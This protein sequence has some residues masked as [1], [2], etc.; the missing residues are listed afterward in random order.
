LFG[1][2]G[3]GGTYGSTIG[4]GSGGGGSSFG[5]GT[6]VYSLAG[7]GGANA[8]AG[9]NGRILLSAFTPPV[10]VSTLTLTPGFVVGDL[11]P[12]APVNLGGT[13][14]EPSSPWSAVLRS[15][16]TV[17]A[18]GITDSSGNFSLGANLPSTV[19]VGEHTITL[20]GTNI[21]GESWTRVVYI[22]VGSSMR[23]TYLSTIGAEGLPALAGP[24]TGRQLAATGSQAEALLPGALALLATG[25]GI[26]LFSARRR[27][28]VR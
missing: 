22:T 26:L 4:G 11:A 2:G 17:F 23:I 7:N 21:T 3:G 16:P 18:S 6:P 19:S 10:I 1:G 24:T 8:T 5:V 13:D 15:T 25:G 12:N 28:A 14:L 27:K 20:F 9:G